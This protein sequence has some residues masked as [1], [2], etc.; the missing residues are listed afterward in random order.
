M[1]RYGWCLLCRNGEPGTTDCQFH[2]NVAAEENLKLS[3]R[4]PVKKVLQASSNISSKMNDTHLSSEPQA[5]LLTTANEVKLCHRLAEDG[6]G[7]SEARPGGEAEEIRPR[8][9]VVDS[10]TETRRPKAG[11]WRRTCRSFV[12]AR[13]V[14]PHQVKCGDFC[15]VGGGFY[16]SR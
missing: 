3:G 13:G 8:R 2:G 7:V 9:Y 4:S 11:G 1:A 16:Q 15:S 6:E 5:H 10:Q 12:S 14:K